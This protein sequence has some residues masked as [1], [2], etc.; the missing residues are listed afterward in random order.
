MIGWLLL[1]LTLIPIGEPLSGKNIKNDEWYMPYYL[2]WGAWLISG[3]SY[4][5]SGIDKFMS[6]SW[7]DGSAII[8][9]IHNPLARDWILRDILLLLPEYILYFQTWFALALE[10][11]FGLFCLFRKGRVTGWCLLL[12]MHISILLVL[13]FADLTLGVLMFHLFIFDSNWFKPKQ[14]SVK[15]VVLFDGVC[16]FCNSWVNFLIT[17]DLNK[18]LHFSPLQ[19]EY[20]KSLNLNKDLQD[21][22]SIAFLYNGIVYSRSK[23]IIL[24]LRQLGGIW[25]FLLVFLIVPQAILN[26]FYNIVAKNRYKFFGKKETCRIPTEEEQNRFLD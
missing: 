14:T 4:T 16:S 21:L 10:I 15:K 5:I 20:A 12:I 6:P 3:L 7:Q 1:A 18:E 26:L 2:F 9:I 24:I 25:F 13:D 22:S 23:A 19:G 17:H 11:S 8:H